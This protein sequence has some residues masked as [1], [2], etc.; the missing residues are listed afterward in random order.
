MNIYL[1]ALIETLLIML[2]VGVC[3]VGVAW[4]A[5][6]SF[7]APHYIVVDGEIFAAAATT[8]G[9]FFFFKMSVKTEKELA[10]DNENL[11]EH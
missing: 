8:I 6:T 11:A 2:I 3:A 4:L 1:N 7:N 10:E 5:L 9:A